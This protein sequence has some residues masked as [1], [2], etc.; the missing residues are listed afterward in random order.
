[1]ALDKGRV[2]LRCTPYAGFATPPRHLH[3]ND[4]DEKIT[5]WLSGSVAWDAA[6]PAP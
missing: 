4:Q 6:D 2:L 5:H 1:M 3:A